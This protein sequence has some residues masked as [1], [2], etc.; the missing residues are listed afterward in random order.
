[1]RQDFGSSCAPVF[2]RLRLRKK[3]FDLHNRFEISKAP[4]C[5]RQSTF[6]RFPVLGELNQS[7]VHKAEQVIR[8]FLAQDMSRDGFANAEWS[9]LLMRA[10]PPLGP[11]EGCLGVEPSASVEGAAREDLSPEPQ[12]ASRGTTN[13]GLEKMLLLLVM[14][15]WRNRATQ[16]FEDNVAI[17]MVEYFAGA[18]GL[19]LE[20]I[21]QGL[22][23]SRF[24]VSYSPLH[25]CLTAQGVRHWTDELA[26]TCAKA[27]CWFGTQCSSWVVM[28]RKQSQRVEQNGFRGNTSRHFV[29]VG[30]QH[31]V[32]TS[33]LY[34]VS[35][36]LGNE[37]VLEQPLNSCMPRARPLE[38]VLK[39]CGASRCNTWLGAYGGE[40]AKPL[41]LWHCAKEFASL[42]RK[43]DCRFKPRFSLVSRKGRRFSGKKGVMK[44][45]Q[46]YTTEFGAA[47]AR[48]TVRLMQQGSSP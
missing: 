8:A 37:P 7:A 32:L 30:N 47:V 11:Q 25:N 24:D 41:Q 6:L 33:M 3:T 21:R 23:A 38:T 44:A 9:G 29:Q 10:Y 5:R 15:C 42:K 39:F 16:G 48:C 45:S 4:E 36:V 28:C 13:I 18:A 40:T 27:L 19:T 34:F 31:M 26:M 12:A 20:H 43:L 35:H 2:G 17:H 1:M 14:R 22:R 46:T